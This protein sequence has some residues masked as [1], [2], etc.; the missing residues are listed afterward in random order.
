MVI[1]LL[2]THVIGVSSRSSHNH[3]GICSWQLT[4]PLFHL[5][6]PTSSRVLL[7]DSDSSCFSPLTTAYC[8]NISHPKHGQG[9]P[10]FASS[11][12]A[13]LLPTLVL[14][15]L[16]SFIFCFHASWGQAMPSQAQCR[17]VGAQYCTTLDSTYCLSNSTFE[18]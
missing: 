10:D 2:P 13:L 9:Y 3:P 11:G 6:T 12:K 7:I 4:S 8:Y 1:I 16:S 15:T 5:L 18:C 17:L 14:T